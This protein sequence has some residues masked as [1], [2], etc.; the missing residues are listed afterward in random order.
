[1]D[2]LDLLSIDDKELQ[3]KVRQKL[4]GNNTNNNRKQMAVDISEVADYLARGWEFV[5]NLPDK[6][7]VI[8]LGS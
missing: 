6:K 2:E 8:R 4:L 5:A 3:E 1:V 7:V